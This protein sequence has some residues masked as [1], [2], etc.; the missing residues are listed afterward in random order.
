MNF[1]EKSDRLRREN[2]R[3]ARE[4]EREMVDSDLSPE[5]RA[6]AQ[7]RARIH[8]QMAAAWAVTMNAPARLREIK[9]REGLAKVNANRRDA[10]ADRLD[11]IRAVFRPGD[12]AERVRSKLEKAGCGNYPL[13]TIQ[14]DLKKLRGN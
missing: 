3:L 12:S 4:A 13:R 11:E 1:A 10:V 7:E 8:W 2:E 6:D 14:R 9:E 5:L